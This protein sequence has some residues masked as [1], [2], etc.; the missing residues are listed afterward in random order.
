MISKARE[1]ANSKAKLVSD[2]GSLAQKN[3]HDSGKKN[4]EKAKKLVIDAFKN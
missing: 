1:S 4:R 2:D 3:V